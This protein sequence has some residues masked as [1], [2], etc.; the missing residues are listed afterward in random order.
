LE[1][2]NDGTEQLE[3]N[4]GGDVRHDAQAEE[5][6]LFEASTSEDGEI[7]E[8]L[9]ESAST[10]GG[11]LHGFGKSNLIDAGQRD[12]KA[13]AI[14]A[15]QGEGKEN[16]PAELRDSKDIDKSREERHIFNSPNKR[17]P[18]PKR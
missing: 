5:G 1:G 16:L 13:Y 6:G 8:H 15:E 7:F 10:F 3:D 9:P 2:R 11:S 12:G 18:K 4:G 14:D 17:D